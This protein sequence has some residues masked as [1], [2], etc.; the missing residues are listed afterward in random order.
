MA[1]L[2]RRELQELNVKASC[3]RLSKLEVQSGWTLPRREAQ[4]STQIILFCRKRLKVG[5]HYISSRHTRGEGGGQWR[6]R[7]SGHE[8][9][10]CPCLRRGRQDLQLGVVGN[11]EQVQ[12]FLGLLVKEMVRLTQVMISEY[13]WRIRE[14]Q[15]FV[16][17]LVPQSPQFAR[18]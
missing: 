13:K 12:G 16:G 2:G 10:T 14:W 7:C 5:D 4:G 11:L 6:Q 17:E 9:V 15:L 8:H 3:P 18:R 1:V